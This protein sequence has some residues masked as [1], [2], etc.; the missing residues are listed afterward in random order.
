MQTMDH[1][2]LQFPQGENLY[3]TPYDYNKTL[4]LDENCVLT[5]ERTYAGTV[6]VP[7]GLTQV[8]GNDF[9]LIH[10]KDIQIGNYPQ[11][12]LTYKLEVYDAI[13]RDLYGTSSP[14]VLEALP[15][16]RD[17]LDLASI[18]D[19]DGASGLTGIHSLTRIAQ[20]LNNRTE[21][22]DDRIIDLRIFK[23]VSIGA[24]G[25]YTSDWETGSEATDL[26]S[27][28]NHD[29]LSIASKNK[30][31]ILDADTDHDSFTIGHYKKDFNPTT[32]TLDL[33]SSGTF[34][35]PSYVYDEAG[36]VTAKDTKTL[37]LPYN[38]KTIALN[39]ALS[40]A[41]T[42]ITTN[43][44]S[45]VADD[46]VET[47]TFIAGNKWIRFAGETT[48][49]KSITFAHLLSVLTQGAHASGW[50]LDAQTPLFGATFNM[51]I[52]AVSFTTDEAGHITAYE[53]SNS[54]TTVQIPM[55]SVV[56]NATGDIVTGLSVQTSNNTSN[57]TFT[58]TRAYVG[59]FALTGYI[60][61][62]LPFGYYASTDNNPEHIKKVRSSIAA[63]DTLQSAIASLQ[64]YA[65]NNQVAIETE[66][67]DR[68]QAITNLING[69]SSDYDTLKELE[70]AIKQEVTDR[71]IAITN[72][73]NGASDGY[74][75][76]KELE[77]AIKQETT[78]RGTALT[79]LVNNASANFD[80][81]GEI[82][83]QVT[84]HTSNTSNPHQVTATQVGLG[85]VTNDAQIKALSSLASGN[86]GKVAIWSAAN[87]LGVS[88]YTIGKSVPSDAVLTATA[89][90]EL[91]TTQLES[92]SKNFDMTVKM[93]NSVSWAY[94]EDTGILSASQVGDLSGVTISI[95][96][97][98]GSSW[99]PVTDPVPA[100]GDEFRAI[101]SRTLTVGESTFSGTK[102]FNQ[103]Y[104]YHE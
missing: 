71:G 21:T 46:Q 103:T 69:A 80:T 95:E 24:Q 97:N 50:S 7:S 36:H 40:T 67:V 94:N 43:N 98:E 60:A 18:G 48:T 70:D 49:G 10:A 25:T 88:D 2:N 6:V 17:P 81:L 85:N 96:K 15:D 37:T 52:P 99:V 11:D 39:N 54:T 90:N 29:T 64:T 33:N 82:E 45:V 77:D 93:P 19:N 4:G 16:G 65:Y 83:T 26:I 92:F 31:I 35:I 47:V 22:I 57:G 79:N 23:T 72:L 68:Q 87:E 104:T 27:D 20:I 44:T 84:N 14:T 63:T 38:Y 42:D 13:L 66:V 59:S 61:P 100:D 34:D 1:N 62:D 76:F 12:R 30:W 9:P 74:D 78:D 75:T 3:S 102:I 28:S 5:N 51:L 56:D 91:I 8:N 73:I 101:A 55:L 86:V 53:Y 58:T 89:I 41:V 32:S